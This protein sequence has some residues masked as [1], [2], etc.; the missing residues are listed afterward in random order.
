[1]ELV[2]DEL[3]QAKKMILEL[4]TMYKD[5]EL[6]ARFK[7]NKKKYQQIAGI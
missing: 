7:K 4:I 1:M 5:N 3:K 6:Y 2:L